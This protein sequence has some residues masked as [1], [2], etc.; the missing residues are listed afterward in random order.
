MMTLAIEKYAGITLAL[1]FILTLTHTVTN[2]RTH[3]RL[4]SCIIII[5]K[6]THK[7]TIIVYC[8]SFLAEHSQKPNTSHRDPLGA[9]SHKSHHK[10]VHGNEWLLHF[11]FIGFNSVPSNCRESTKICRIVNNGHFAFIVDTIDLCLRWIAAI[12]KR[13]H[14][15]VFS[16][17][18][19]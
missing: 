12:D 4:E 7:R 17:K 18:L 3:P 9:H 15:I 8:R 13:F 11:M 19:S 2:S 16:R 14:S 5:T 1:T 10:N 6:A